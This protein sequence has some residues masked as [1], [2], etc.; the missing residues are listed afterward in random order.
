MIT[1]KD[2]EELTSDQPKKCRNPLMAIQKMVYDFDLLPAET[3]QSDEESDGMIK[4]TKKK[5]KVVQVGQKRGRK[6]SLNIKKF[7]GKINLK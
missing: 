6:P 4:S 5:K 2:L 3:E 7:K 1:E